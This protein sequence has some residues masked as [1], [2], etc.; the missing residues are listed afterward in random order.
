MPTTTFAHSTAR[1][2]RLAYCLVPVLL[3]L[4]AALVPSFYRQSAVPRGFAHLPRR[5]CAGLT[6]RGHPPRATD[7]AG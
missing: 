6:P 1:L 3:G 4:G 5:P 7:E 2:R